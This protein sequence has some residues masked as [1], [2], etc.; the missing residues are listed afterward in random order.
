MVQVFKDFTALKL[1][2]IISMLILVTGCKDLRSLDG[3]YSM[4]HLGEY[5][6]VYFKGDSIRVAS[7]NEWAKLSD[8]KKIMISR[9]TIFFQTFGE[10]R[11]S[12]MAKLK[13]VDKNKIQMQNLSNGEILTMQRIEDRVTFENINEFWKG[14]INRRHSETCN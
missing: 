10:W 12:I 11:D 9:D 4:C 6:E 7:E 5:T 14:F 8:W 1:C 13:Y 2:Y 3:N